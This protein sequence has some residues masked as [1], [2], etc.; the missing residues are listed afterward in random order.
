[1]DINDIH[2]HD[3]RLRRVIE[4]CDKDDLFFEVD[5]PVEWECSRFEPRV[6]AFRDVLNYRV[7][8][9]P[10]AGAPD[11]LDVREKG[12]VGSRRHLEI[13][14]NAGVRSLLCADVELLSNV[15]A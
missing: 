10:F 11:I 15:T 3:C 13:Q 12:I 5:Y 14:T 1:M 2:F 7:E 6:I 9:G 8:E 4:H